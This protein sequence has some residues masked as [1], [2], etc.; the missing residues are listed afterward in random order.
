MSVITSLLVSYD[1]EATAYVQS[2]GLKA[3]AVVSN[4]L[5]TSGHQKPTGDFFIA[6]VKIMKLPQ[7]VNDAI[8][9]TQEFFAHEFFPWMLTYGATP[10][11]IWLVGFLFSL[12]VWFWVY[13]KAVIDKV[14][15]TLLDE[16][17]VWIIAILLL[18]PFWPFLLG[19]IVAQK[20]LEN[21]G[22]EKIH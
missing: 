7:L 10:A 2:L 21:L 5:Q 3:V 15:V 14:G 17:I 6:G 22:E 20:L 19:L 8:V 18:I 12:A 16:I 1:R 11:T 13:K 9:S 4:G